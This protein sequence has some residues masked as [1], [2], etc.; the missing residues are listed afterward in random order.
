MNRP[1]P[2]SFTVPGVPQRQGDHRTS[3]AGHIYETN[4]HLRPWR[5]VALTRARDARPDTDGPVFIGAVR[6]TAGFFF[7]RPKSHYRTGKNADQLRENA[8]VWH[9]SA[10]DA[11]KLQRAVGDVLTQAGVVIDDR[12][13]AHWTAGKFYGDP[14][15]DVVVEALG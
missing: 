10:P 12:I 4:R 7:P 8:P 11:D 2:V 15:V 3:R 1:A 5:E 9:T 14:R 13:I 6:V